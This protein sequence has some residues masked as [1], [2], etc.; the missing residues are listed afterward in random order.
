MS[1]YEVLNSHEFA[2][3]VQPGWRRALEWLPGAGFVWLLFGQ[4]IAPSQKLYFQLLIPLLYIP[5]LYLICRD[6]RSIARR[7]TTSVTFSL[8]LLLWLWACISMSWSVNIDVDREARRMLFVFLFV[9]G[10]AWWAARDLMRM[11]RML[12]IAGFAL[13]ISAF[14]AM[15]L[16]PWRTPEFMDRLTGFCALNNP[17]LAAYVMGA[18]AVWLINWM[19]AKRSGQLLWGLALL[20]LSVFVVMTWTRGAII[21]LA[22]CLILMPL[23]DRRRVA[24]VVALITAAG[25]A[26]VVLFFSSQL[27]QRGSSFRVGIFEAALSKIAENPWLGLGKAT[28]YQIVVGPNTWLHSHNLF[29]HTAI[30]LGVF[31]LAVLIAIWLLVL[32]RAWQNRH[33]ALGR[34]L[35]CLWIFS[36]IAVQFD[37]TR[38]WDAPGPFWL[39][40]WLPI[41]Y[42]LVLEWAARSGK[43][44]GI[45]TE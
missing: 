45:K 24:R 5:A 34:G 32:L 13:A 16:W 39:V 8:F 6:W 20:T 36:T 31:A 12:Q 1:R 40:T 15:A 21:P 41:T 2:A 11:E 37:G 38:L 9:V 23:W 43:A 14:L 27:M 17:I 22:L 3:G 33:S 18:A 19:P 35:I 28:D 4:A 26:V 29:T 30:E 25:A 7:A 44:S 10:G 42:C